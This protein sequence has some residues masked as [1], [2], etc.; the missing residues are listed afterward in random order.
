MGKYGSRM[1]EDLSEPE[2]TSQRHIKIKFIW[3]K[4][5]C[6]IPPPPN[7]KVCILQGRVGQLGTTCHGA[8]R[9]ASGNSILEEYREISGMGRS[10]ELTLVL[11]AED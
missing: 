8:A 7:I 6:S 2:Q 3:G 4:G 10:W 11:Q 5:L 9:K 1:R